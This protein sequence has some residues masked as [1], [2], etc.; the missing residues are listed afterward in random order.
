M[1]NFHLCNKQLNTLKIKDQ[2]HSYYYEPYNA[3]KCKNR[4]VYFDD[5]VKDFSEDIN[6]FGF[7]PFLHKY[8]FEQKK[9]PNIMKFKSKEFENGYLNY[10]RTSNSHKVSNSKKVRYSTEADAPAKQKALATVNEEP[11]TETLSTNRS[12]FNNKV[13]TFLKDAIQK[14]HK[15]DGAFK[16][17]KVNEANLSQPAENFKKSNDLYEKSENDEN[18]DSHK[19]ASQILRIEDDNKH[20]KSNRPHLQQTDLIYHPE[21]NIIIKQSRDRLQHSVPFSIKNNYPIYFGPAKLKKDQI[22]LRKKLMNC[23]NCALYNN[24]DSKKAS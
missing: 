19:A 7:S 9:D 21:Q 14:I 24:F 5:I 12:N 16:D 23:G 20:K 6:S 1:S 18:S 17:E 2:I 8:T 22:K 3:L 10:I 11:A 15:A 13:T 4:H